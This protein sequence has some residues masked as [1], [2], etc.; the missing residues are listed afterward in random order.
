M[1]YFSERET[2]GLN[3]FLVRMLEAARHH[4]GVPF[5][6]TSGYRSDEHNSAAGG[7]SGS[8]HTRSLAVDIRCAHSG[9]RFRIVESALSVG[10]KRIGLYDKHIHLDCDMSLPQGVIWLGESK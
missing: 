8:A 3:P 10:F 1:S 6:I 5:V 9:D 2:A 7:V 4:S